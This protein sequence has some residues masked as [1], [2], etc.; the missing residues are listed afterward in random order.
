LAF[1]YLLIAAG[2]VGAVPRLPGH[3]PFYYLLIA[4]IVA[5]SLRGL[6]EYAR[7]STIS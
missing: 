1:Y 7:L 3:G 4:A 2:E 6:E 5:G